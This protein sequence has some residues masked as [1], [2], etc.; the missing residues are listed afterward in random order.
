[1]TR[2]PT[3]HHDEPR[4]PAGTPIAPS[5]RGPGG[6]RWRAGPGGAFGAAVGMAAGRLD[7]ALQAGRR[8]QVRGVYGDWLD[9]VR[10][11][12]SGDGSRH[13]LVRSE[14]GYTDEM[15]R[16]TYLAREKLGDGPSTRDW[17]QEVSAQLAPHPHT[18]GLM[19]HQ[20]VESYLDRTDYTVTG[21]A[22][23]A[24]GQVEFRQYSDG[25]RL[26][27]KEIHGGHDGD[28]E[29]QKETEVSLIARAL[30]APVPA[31]V[32]DPHN[33]RG[34]L[35]QYIPDAYAD[36]PTDD[37]GTYLTAEHAAEAHNA[38]AMLTPPGR[39][40]GLLDALTGNRDRSRQNVRL[41]EGGGVVGI[42]NGRVYLRTRFTDPESWD[43]II[44]ES[45][46]MDQL[47]LNNYAGKLFG[48]DLSGPLD[49]QGSPPLVQHYFSPEAIREARQRLTPI[50]DQL[51]PNTQRGLQIGFDILDRISTGTHGLE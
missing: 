43:G 17:A 32:P 30:G 42:D 31:V 24:Y 26:A 8:F 47:T 11:E 49:A 25:T 48:R 9:A 4:W 10:F 7:E 22:G 28:E 37:F 3:T 12:D 40:L 14:R 46:A 41:Q 51:R 23:G 19:T 29:I 50:W 16:E 2:E 36:S 15:H 45:A 20:Q 21:T 38:A 39:L 1:M 33:Q 6:G 13:L 5:G 35:M 27:Y 18:W 44:D 34:M